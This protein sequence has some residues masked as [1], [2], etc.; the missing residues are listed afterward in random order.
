MIQ[1]RFRRDA[2]RHVWIEVLAGSNGDE[3]RHVLNE[4]WLNIASI[5]LA[6]ERRRSAGWH[7][8]GFDGGDQVA[9]QPIQIIGRFNDDTGEPN[10]RRWDVIVFERLQQPRRRF[11]FSQH[12]AS[13]RK[14]PFEVIGVDELLQ[15]CDVRMVRR[16]QRKALGKRQAQPLVGRPRTLHHRRARFQCNID[17]GYRVRLCRRCRS[18]AGRQPECS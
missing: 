2:D 13:S 16:V 7:G 18:G 12:R 5:L 9:L 17:C 1:I 6:E 3:M 11:G 10:R 4:R 15:Q 8:V 14:H